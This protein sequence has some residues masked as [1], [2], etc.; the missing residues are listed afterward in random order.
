MNVQKTRDFFSQPRENIIE[1]LKTLRPSGEYARDHIR[2]FLQQELENKLSN[3]DSYYPDWTYSLEVIFEDDLILVKL[4]ARSFEGFFWPDQFCQAIS[5]VKRGMLDGGLEMTRKSEAVRYLTTKGLRKRTLEIIKRIRTFPRKTCSVREL[6]DAILL[7][8]HVY[9]LLEKEDTIICNDGLGEVIAK[10]GP[11][12]IALP[13]FD[14]LNLLAPD[15]REIWSIQL[16]QLGDQSLDAPFEEIPF[17]GTILFKQEALGC[18]CGR[19]ERQGNGMQIIE[20]CP[21]T[22]ERKVLDIPWFYY[23][24]HSPSGATY[25]FYPKNQRETLE[26]EKT[27]WETPGEWRRSRGN[28]LVE[29]TCEIASPEFQKIHN[30]IM[31]VAMRLR[32]RDPEMDLDHL[33]S[34]IYEAY[35]GRLGEEDV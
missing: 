19:F 2:A 18:Q 11:A 31:A 30:R 34:E 29:L 33:S 23:T 35:L 22:R 1:G 4:S 21:K 5:K 26:K 10:H 9:H 14:A 15:H 32:D 28:E 16:M 3:F 25:T 6:V 27:F 24:I 8:D 13:G 20:R 7:G 17:D 12:E